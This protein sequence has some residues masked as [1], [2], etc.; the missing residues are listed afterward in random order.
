MSTDINE[1]LGVSSTPGQPGTAAQPGK[2]SSL[3]SIAG[4]IAVLAWITGAV[5][6]IVGLVSI[7]SISRNSYGYRDNSGQS[8]LIFL[9]YLYMGVFIVISLLAQSGIIKVL[10]DIEENTRKANSK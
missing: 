1:A 9:A 6:M 2:Y 5:I 3:K 4:I 7:V 8:I 10:I